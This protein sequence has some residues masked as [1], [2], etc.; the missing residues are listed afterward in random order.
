M[1]PLVTYYDFAYND[2][3]YFFS[4]NGD[5]TYNRIGAEAQEI[6]EKFLKHLI[7][8]YDLPQ[9]DNSQTQHDMAMRTH[10]LNRL[11]KY[12]KYT[13][14]LPLTEKAQNYMHIIDGFYFSTR[15]PGEDSVTL[16][17]TD[18]ENCKKAVIECK[19]NVDEIIRIIEKG[20]L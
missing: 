6:C 13:M 10:S 5:V 1:E 17:K 19:K 18:I 9:N 12:I 2:Y 15:Y 3:Q 7:D 8:T 16:D 14:N 20:D 11:I 4:Y